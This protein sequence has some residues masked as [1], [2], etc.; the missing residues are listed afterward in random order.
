M[1]MYGS[2]D[3]HFYCDSCKAF[4][5]V[6]AVQTFSEAINAAKKGAGG[7]LLRSDGVVLCEECKTNPK[8]ELLDEDEREGGP[9]NWRKQLK[10]QEQSHD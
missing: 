8:P 3:A 5:E 10:A 4:A 1:G 2:Y 7:W 9:W 6:G